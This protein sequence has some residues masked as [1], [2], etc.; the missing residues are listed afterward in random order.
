MTEWT[1]Y[2]DAVCLKDDKGVVP[3]LNSHPEYDSDAETWDLYFEYDDYGVHDLVA[4]P[5]ESTEEAYKAIREI[6]DEREKVA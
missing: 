4:L 2:I 3:P 5:F 1:E 6:L